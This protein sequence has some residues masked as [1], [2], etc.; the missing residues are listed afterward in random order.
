[1]RYLFFASLLMAQVSFGQYVEETYPKTLWSENDT[2]LLRYKDYPGSDVFTASRKDRISPGTDASPGEYMTIV[3][4]KDSVRLNYHNHVPYGHAIFVNLASSKGKTVLRLHFNDM[5]NYFSPAYIRKNKGNVQFDIPEAYELAN[6]IWTLSP[7]GRR[8]KDLYTEGD[9]YK[10]VM[11]YFKPYAGHRIFKELDFPDSV[12]FDKYY[13]F[14]ENSFAFNFKEPKPGAKDTKLLFNGPYYYVFGNDLADS[15]LFGRLLPLVE[16]FAA[17][18]KFREFYKSNLAFYQ[19][20]IAREKS[21]MPVRQMWDWLEREFVKP[22]YQ[23]YRVVFSPLIGGSHSTQRYSTEDTYG[24]FSE[25][26]MFVCGAGRYDTIS[27]FTEKQKEGLMSGIV[28]TEIDHNYVNPATSKYRKVV[29]SI[30]S[31]RAVWVRSSMSSNYYS[32]PES[33]FNE[34]MTHAVFCLYVLDVYDK[35]TADLVIDRREVMNVDRRG[36]Y[37]FREFDR[38][39]IRLRQEYKNLKVVELY[40]YI[41]DWCRKQ[42]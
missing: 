26:V 13:S 7:S 2:F 16:D 10:K 22:N 17:K 14:R 30:F 29:D 40:P 19:K 3:Y 8:A 4:G 1:M 15:S 5:F 20:E 36:F 25:N 37:K 39:L 12:Y 23:S 24:S 9:Y 11:A 41:L 31:K 6:I 27:A 32:H 18:S 38:E 42:L 35:S 33:V 28:F 34:Y 21:L